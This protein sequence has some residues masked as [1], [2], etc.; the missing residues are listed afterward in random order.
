MESIGF[1]SVQEVRSGCS[2]DNV[3]AICAASI[4]GDETAGVSGGIDN[5]RTRIALLRKIV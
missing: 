2:V 4:A 3:R 5:C 1:H